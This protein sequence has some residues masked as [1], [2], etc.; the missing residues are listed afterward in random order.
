MKNT[1]LERLARRQRAY[2]RCHPWRLTAQGLYVPHSYDEPQAVSWW[3]DV[4]FVHAGRR[5]IVWW[6]HP[7]LVYRDALDERARAE[8]GP[9]P[10]TDWPMGGKTKHYRRLGASRK[11]LV[12]YECAPAPRSLIEHHARIERAYARLSAEGIDHVVRPSYRRERLSWATGV[13]LVAPVE[14][15]NERE[16]AA[17]AELARR[18]ARG[19]TTLA[20]EFPDYRYGREEWTRER[21][22][23]GPGGRLE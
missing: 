21:P 13:N 1:H 9:G 18:L 15:R 7:R 19:E 3:D 10:E 6:R 4:G 23:A 14:V 17:L 16:L 8:A 2:H 20:A 11:K 22:E 12:S 5:F